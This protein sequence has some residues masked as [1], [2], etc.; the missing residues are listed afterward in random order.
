MW[1]SLYTI[2][3]IY[4]VYK[5]GDAMTQTKLKYIKANVTPASNRVL[6]LIAA[7]QGKYMYEVIEDV[8]R[9]KYPEYF[10]KLGCGIEK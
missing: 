10:Q 3:T 7:E 9:A 8:L 1:V 4:T 2:H 5:R 6:K